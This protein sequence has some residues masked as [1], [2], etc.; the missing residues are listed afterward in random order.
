M[1]EIQWQILE[2]N[3]AESSCGGTQAAFEGKRNTVSVEQNNTYSM[4]SSEEHGETFPRDE[5]VHPI[6][7]PVQPRQHQQSLGAKQ[8]LGCIQLTPLRVGRRS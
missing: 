1:N 5:I 3:E 2:S 4:A 7:P 6:L 8:G